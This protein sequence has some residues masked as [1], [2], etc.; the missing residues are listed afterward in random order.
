MESAVPIVYLPPL[1]ASN[2]PSPN[3]LLYRPILWAKQQ[4]MNTMAERFSRRDQRKY[5]AYPA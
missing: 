2:V 1:K 4:P 5:V 3:N